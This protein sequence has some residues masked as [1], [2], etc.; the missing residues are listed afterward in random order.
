M[1]GRGILV[2]TIAQPFGVWQCGTLMFWLSFSCKLL[3]RGMDKVSYVT[4]SWASCPSVVK[5]N[6]LELFC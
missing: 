3:N 1:N 2:A 4:A 6:R 5:Q